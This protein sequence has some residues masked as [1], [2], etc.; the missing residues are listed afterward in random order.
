MNVKVKVDDVSALQSFQLRKGK[1]QKPL[2]IFMG[3]VTTTNP[4][5]TSEFLSSECR[6]KA[7]CLRDQPSCPRAESSSSLSF[8]DPTC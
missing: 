8:S 1:E 5:D 4:H 2:N 3:S 6:G 7:G